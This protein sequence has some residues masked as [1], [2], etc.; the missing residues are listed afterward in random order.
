MS[1]DADVAVIGAGVVG[2]AVET[3]LNLVRVGMVVA[4]GPMFFT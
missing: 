3:R 2:I 1:T 4:T